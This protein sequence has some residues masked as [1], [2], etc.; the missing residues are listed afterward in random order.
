MALTL[1]RGSCLSVLF[2]IPIWIMIE[3]WQK[4]RSAP[5][6]RGILIGGPTFGIA[7]YLLL[8]SQQI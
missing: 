8:V 1:F 7:P 6:L 2:L 4:V 3:G 5:W